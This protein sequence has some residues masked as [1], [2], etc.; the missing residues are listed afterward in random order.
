M[1]IN[2][3][4]LPIKAVADTDRSLE[5]LD[6]DI[7][8]AEPEGLGKGLLDKADNRRVVRFRSSFG[9]AG[10]DMEGIVLGLGFL[11][12]HI[13]ELHQVV[14]DAAL[15]GACEIQLTTDDV[16]KAIERFEI[17]WIGDGD[18]EIDAII[19]DGDCA[20]AAGDILR[21]CEDDGGIEMEAVEIRERNACI[22]SERLGDLCLSEGGVFEKVLDDGLAAGE[23]GSCQFDLLSR[24]GAGFDKEF[25]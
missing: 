7:G 23:G 9:I 13:V 6:M 15:C 21:D 16:W 4:E 20:V 8:S 10:G 2:V 12:F 1:G 25:S 18:S 19:G 17:E 3:D 5:R 11:I 24:K 14:V 22:G